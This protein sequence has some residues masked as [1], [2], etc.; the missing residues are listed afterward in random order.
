MS[1]PVW[2][3]PVLLTNNEKTR[4]LGASLYAP[5]CGC[6]VV[7]GSS[8]PSGSHCPAHTFNDIQEGEHTLLVAIA[9]FKP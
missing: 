4:V 7:L 9:E 3:P 6:S 5:L 1:A 2:D 8:L